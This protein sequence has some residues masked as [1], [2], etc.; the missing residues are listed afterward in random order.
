[1]NHDRSDDRIGVPTDNMLSDLQACKN[2]YDLG[3]LLSIQPKHLAYLL[4]ILPEDRRYT[5]L[6]L[7]KKN[8]GSRLIS[9]PNP[10]LKAVQR[11]LSDLL[12]RCQKEIDQ[13]HR[14]R[15][16]F[17]FEKDLTIY[18]NAQ[19]HVSRRWVFNIDL[20]NFFPTINF[21]RVRGFFINNRSF[22]LEPKIATLIAQ[23]C[24]HKNQLPQGAPTSPIVSNLICGSLDFRLAR[25]A[26]Q[27]RC[28]YS[29]YADDITFSTNQKAFP[30]LI[31][32]ECSSK[33]GWTVSDELGSRIQ[34]AG[35]QVNSKKT[36][37]SSHESRQIVTGLVVN[38]KVNMPR[39]NY[40]S[41]RAA[42]HSILRN[43]DW[44]LPR[45]TDTFHW[46]CSDE[47]P[48]IDKYSSLE[49]RLN[50]LFEISDRSDLREA[51]HRFFKP[52]SISRTYS[53]FLFFKYLVRPSRPLI[54]TE[55]VSDI[56]YIKAALFAKS[57]SADF[58]VNHQSAGKNDILVDFFNYPKSASRVM[59]LPGGSSNFSVFLE[60]HK[61]FTKK[62]STNY[63]RR[64]VVLV[65]DNDSGIEKNLKK[66]LRDIYN[67][68]ISLSD[69]SNF[70]KL[71]KSFFIVK[72]PSLSKKIESAIEDFLDPSVFSI[73]LN[74]K[75]FSRNKEYDTA[76]H[77]GKFILGGHLVKNFS[78]FSFGNF[79][80]IL[81]R[82]QAALREAD[83]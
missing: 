23:I 20:E 25:L 66:C 3:A 70:Y 64:P 11:R 71:D 77:F 36:R 17:G 41:A 74:G 2:S 59:G 16:S 68:D 28:T 75:T 39:E 69:N 9:I 5:E 32:I 49:G 31:A 61:S 29:R 35:F 51:N 14:P 50:Y 55:G 30:S 15:R 79:D 58:L 37:L 43:R 46:N 56:L 33:Q 21:G 7:S 22:A 54:I 53:D 62:L 83:S 27:A 80:A 34:S 47:N 6:C 60:R 19:E 18:D 67:I 1:M 8:G 24:C 63:R 76:R 10:N 13:N 48:K 81:S 73:T 44:H 45:F 12:Y 38:D 72:T 78:N 42:V 82:V 65:L 26:R 52:S 57:Q 4:F 40:K